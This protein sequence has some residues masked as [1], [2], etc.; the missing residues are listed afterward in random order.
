[1]FCARCRDRELR[2]DDLEGWEVHMCTECGG[3]WI[4]GDVFREAIRKPPP[5]TV[6]SVKGP[7]PQPAV[8]EE[9][10]LSCPACGKAM[11]KGVYSY[12]SGVIIDRCEPC[13]GI[14][15]DRGELAKIRAFV[16]WKPPQE[17]VLMA[18]LQAEGVRR[19]METQERR[20]GAGGAMRGR[21]GLEGLI[22]F[23]RN[24]FSDSFE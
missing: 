17:R 21:G 8:W 16:N 19:R 4:G 7:A 20:W 14:W 2:V 5:A 18:Q 11:K 6:M 23:L 10:A 13:G 12:S 24:L 1:M 15:L 3:L 22:P 9:S